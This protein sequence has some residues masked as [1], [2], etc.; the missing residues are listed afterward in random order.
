[1]LDILYAG[2]VIVI[3]QYLQG[4]MVLS[5]LGDLKAEEI[6]EQSALLVK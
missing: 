6:R 4:L 1:M 3:I 2:R 5:C